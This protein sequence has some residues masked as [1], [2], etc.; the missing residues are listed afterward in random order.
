MIALFD[1][2]APL[3]LPATRWARNLTTLTLALALAIIAGCSKPSAAPNTSAA[4]SGSTS[5]ESTKSK[6]AVIGPAAARAAGIETAEAGPARIRTTLTLYGSIRPNAERE[7]D[8]RARYPGVVRNVSKR[9]GDWVNKGEELLTVESNESL[10]V[11]AIRAPLTGQVL[12]RRTNPGDAVDGSS[13]LMKVADLSTVWVEFAVFAHELRQVRPG[14]TL[15]F[16]GATADEN[17]EARITYVSRAGEADS[18]SVIAR[19]VT[20]NRNA[21]WVPGQ[22]VTGDV[23]ITDSQVPVAVSAGALQQLQGKTI[24]FVQKGEHFEPR[25]IEVGRRARDT[26]EVIQ[27]LKSGEIYAAHNSYLIKADLLKTEAE[28]D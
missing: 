2:I 10:Q 20:D 28:E 3:A 4:N 22:F 16:R 14:M 17:G 12:E 25:P 8:I 21:R 6:T 13:V 26:I 5:T 11:Y 15:S 23:V 18:Q 7:Q 19:A 9:V 1:R 24:V 27:G